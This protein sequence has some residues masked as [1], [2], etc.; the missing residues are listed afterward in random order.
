MSDETGVAR[1]QDTD[2]RTDP[3]S[4]HQRA[5]RFFA[6]L[7]FA[8]GVL[9]SLVVGLSGTG[10][11][12]YGES[13]WWIG[14]LLGAGF[15]LAERFTIHVDVNRVGWTV[16]FT[17]IPLV[18]GLLVA[19]F[20]VV[21]L[22]HLLAGMGMLT[23]TLLSRRALSHGV[24]NAGVMCLEVAIPFGMVALLSGALQGMGPAWLP[25]LL[26]ALSSPLVSAVLALGA[27]RVL[28]GE[29]RLSGAVRMALYILVIGLLNT[30]VA[31][32]GYEVAVAQPWGWALVVFLC[33]TVVGLY[34]AYSGLL[35]ER[36]DLEALSEVS[37]AVARSGQDAISR[38]A[39]V[40]SHSQTD[41]VDWRRVTDRIRD[42]LNANRVVLHL[43][44]DGP[45]EVVT[46]VSGEDQ[47]EASAQERPWATRVDPLLRLPGSQVRYF[48]AADAPEDVRDALRAR[49]ATEALVVP[50]HGA[51]QVLGTVE[52]HD[53]ISR[54]RGFGLADVRLLRTLASHLATALDN[55][56]LLGRLRHDAYHD[57]LTGLLN[58]QGFRELTADR[59]RSERR[60]VLLRLDLEVLSTVSEALGH[61]WGDRMV[62]AAGR[63]MRD[64]LGPVAVLARLEGGSFAVLLAG[65]TDEEVA[66]LAERL[67][68]EVAAPYPVDR[69]T[70]EA[71]AV[72]GYA[73]A[74]V[75]P[76]VRD[77]ADSMLQHA[78]V[79]LRAARN[80][81]VAVRGY[82]PSMGQ[83]FLRRFQL[84]THFRQALD[85]GQVEV[86]F[87]PKI[88]LRDREVI[89]V[90]AL[91][92]WSHPEFGRLDPDEFVPA[93]EATGLVDALTCFVMERALEQV[94]GWLD[95]GLRLSAAVN[96]S[97]RN[98]ADEDFPDVVAE[99]LG[100]T[101]V[102]PELLTFELTESGVM[103][104]PERA[105][106][107]LRRLHA[108][109]VVLA[110]D[111]FGTGYSSLAYLRQLPVDEVKIDKSF[112]FGM[113]SDLSDMAV[114]RSIIELG[115][116]LGLAVV[117]EGVEEDAV[118]DQLVGMG[119]D[120]AQ[121]YLISRPLPPDR[122][123]AWLRAR[124]VRARGSR[125]RLVLTLLS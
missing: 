28:G 42:Q 115:H 15:L 80:G 89:G 60:L 12:P 37:L 45:S 36:R 53:R 9:A 124:T 103:A 106:P 17:E 8:A 97:V 83:I 99:A 43:F 102:P 16:S 92:R 64:V 62:V 111:D 76:E 70:V 67:R 86:H 3:R 21:L 114:V 56:Q 20:E 29:I 109:G 65:H 112:V 18:V 110:V 98:L 84:V 46:T 47:G 32:V 90:E 5:F 95:R 31:L 94:R 2:P 4:A 24:Y 11:A 120:T 49:G 73:V 57:P 123:E 34:H 68:A 39:S 14:P 116:S 58:R 23:G 26:G 77:D 54:W 82:A 81:D 10:F 93:V 1:S 100:R 30:S 13:I 72:V 19:P 78:D 51:Q 22:A 117:A 55:R 119:C 44:R 61:A 7:V 66:G 108:L 52:A 71:G 6:F 75:D 91:V 38:P 40:V 79:A 105:L 50:L 107:V 33:A 104:D 41:P 125:D 59:L 63:R 87:Q 69:L 35:R 48:R 96:L 121:G 118:R 27:M 74:G 25:V 122:F 85:T 101:G 88:A 113:G